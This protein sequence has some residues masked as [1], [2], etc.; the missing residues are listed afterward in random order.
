LHNEV[1]VSS[2]HDVL[3]IVCHEFDVL[4]DTVLMLW[5]V[6]EVASTEYGVDCS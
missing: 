1:A 6:E 3:A 5:I 4:D 2:V